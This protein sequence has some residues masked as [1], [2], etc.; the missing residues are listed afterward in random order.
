MKHYA[1]WAAPLTD[2]LKNRAKF[3]TK[4]EWNEGMQEGLRKIKE[5]MAENVILAIANS[6]KPYILRL[7]ASGYAVGAVLSQL[8]GEGRSAPALSFPE[9]FLGSPGWANGGGPSANRKPML[10]S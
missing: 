6:Y 2:A 5:G 1:E 3:Q 9:S 10:L 4:V 7:D 8:D